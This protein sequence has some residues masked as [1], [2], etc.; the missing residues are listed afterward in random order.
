ML[1]LDLLG[2]EE[3][4]ERVAAAIAI[5]VAVGFSPF[6]GAHIWIA[7][8][9]AFLLRLNKLDTVLGQFAGNPWTIPP[10][11]A[12]GYALGRLLLG[13]KAGKMPKF[14]WSHMLE[15]QFWSGPA[16]AFLLGTTI[17]AAGFGIASYFAA[18]EVLRWYHRR[19]PRVAARAARRRTHR[20]SR[21]TRRVAD[22]PRATASGERD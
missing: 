2:R 1:L 10:V 16:K 14:Q 21:H 3:T 20:R 12:A 22:A 19:H 6:L 9:L 11:F 18:R 7:L 13:Y 4:P 8:G 15:S 5:G 17:L